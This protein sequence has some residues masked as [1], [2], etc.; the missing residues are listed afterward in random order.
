MHQDPH[1]KPFYPKQNSSGPYLVHSSKM[2]F[3]IWPATLFS[4]EKSMHKCTLTYKLGS[5]S[6][7]CQQVCKCG[8]TSPPPANHKMY[9][10]LVIKESCHRHSLWVA[11]TVS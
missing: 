4:M 10:I 3:G 11:E 8:Q 6:T 9:N 5:K 2:A 1:K 7:I